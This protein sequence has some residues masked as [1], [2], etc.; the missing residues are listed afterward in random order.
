MRTCRAE[1]RERRRTVAAVAASVAAF[2]IATSGG[3]TATMRITAP[4]PDTAMSGPTRIEIKIEPDAA[5]SALRTAMITVDG[6]LVCTLEKPP[7]VCTYDSGEAVRARHVRVAATLSDGTK[8]VDTVFTKDLGYSEH[9]RADAVLV[10]VIVTH[11]G[12]FVK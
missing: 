10:P 12:Q 5:L 9:V 2:S 3:Q 1:A 6:R 4:T 8:L 11:D 7:L